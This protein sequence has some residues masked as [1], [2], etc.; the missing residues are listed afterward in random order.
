MK[1]TVSQALAE[2]IVAFDY[3]SLPEE[4]R[5]ESRKTLVNSVGTAIGSFPLPDVQL[6]LAYLTSQQSDGPCTLLASGHRA[7]AGGAAFA[8][9]VMF[10]NLGQE[11]THLQSGTHPVETTTPIVLALAEE[12]GSSGRA[13]LEALVVGAEVTM[14]VARMSLTP[15]VKYDLCEAPA[16]YG[17]VGAAAAASKLF[18]LDETATAHALGLAANFAAGLSECIR[19]G[20]DEYH[21]IVALASQHAELSAR[22]AR[23]G[24]ISASTSFEGDGGFYHLFAGISRDVLADHD[25]VADVM[26]RL[27][28]HWGL[29]ELIYKPYPVNYF[30]Q[31]FADGGLELRTK[32]ELRVEDIASVRI[33]VGQLA[34]TS[35]AM[36]PPPYATRGGV[37]GSTR[38]CVASMLARGTLGLADTQ[39]LAAADIDRIMQQTE[40]IADEGLTTARVEV[41]TQAGTTYTFDGDTDGRDYRLGG[42]DIDNIFRLA[43]TGILPD[44]QMEELLAQLWSVEALPHIRDVMALTVAAKGGAQ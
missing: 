34:S 30:N 8:N 1:Q 43:V 5:A 16:V 33:T 37:L 28:S 44:A 10:N 38:F 32:H 42:P 3:D 26:S 20:T 15:A 31:V 21:F 7:N 23:S 17:T 13:V 39:D 41:T 6:A 11:E 14:A 35:G 29:P 9:G 40:V 22:L 2:W 25:V 36:V 27:G 19:T 4:I 18:G 24:A 12:L